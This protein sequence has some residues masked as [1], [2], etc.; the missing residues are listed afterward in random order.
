MSKFEWEVI[1]FRK[2]EN[3]CNITE[4]AKIPGGWL[5]SNFHAVMNPDR[6]E[7]ISESIIKVDDP[8]HKWQVEKI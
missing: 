7:S 8:A 1:I 4:R 5:I 3:R 2:A 6:S